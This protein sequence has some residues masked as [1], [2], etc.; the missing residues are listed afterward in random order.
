M[1]IAIKHGI[2]FPGEGSSNCHL[3]QKETKVDL[4]SVF[5]AQLKNHPACSGR[6]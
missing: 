2:R 6:I 1:Q 4:N 3:V 5:K